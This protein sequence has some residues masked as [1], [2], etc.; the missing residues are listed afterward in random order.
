MVGRVSVLHTDCQGFESLTAH[1]KKIHEGSPQAVT[2]CGEP[3][4]TALP[5]SP[6]G[7]PFRTA[8]NKKTASP[9]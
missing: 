3:F 4:Y 1:Q 6:V 2:V 5:L 7:T 9:R 8:V